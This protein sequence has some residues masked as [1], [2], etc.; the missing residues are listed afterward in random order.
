MSY[1]RTTRPE[2]F[3]A[4]GFPG[5]TLQMLAHPESATFITS[6]VA[7]GGHAADRHVHESDQLYFVLEG[8][9]QVELGQRR[10]RAAAGCLVYIPAGLPHRNWNEGRDVELHLEIIAPSYRP[11]RPMLALVDAAAAG[12]SGQE[13]YVVSARDSGQSEFAPRR[14]TAPNAGA[15]LSM[16]HEP[17][18]GPVGQVH[19][20]DLDQF[21]YILRGTLTVDIG[22]EKHYARERTLVMLPAGI[23]HR[24]GNQSGAP[25]SYLIVNV[26]AGGRHT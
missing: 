10:H 11:G 24:T 15:E 12:A 5:Y 19:T 23:P 17:A 6:R 25:V 2:A 1:V 26:P 21:Y 16:G 9:M 7:P 20:H 3:E 22:E 18:D 4:T 13:G 14:L 8:E